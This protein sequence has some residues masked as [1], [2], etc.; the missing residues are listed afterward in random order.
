MPAAGFAV[1]HR[2]AGVPDGAN[3]YAGLTPLGGL[4]FG[5]AAGAGAMGFG[6]VFA[7]DPGSGVERVVYSFAG[8]ADG[9]LPYAGLAVRGRVLLGVTGRGGPANL[10]TI[11]ALDPLDGKE[12]MLHRFGGGAD[13][14][15][16]HDGL[17]EHE[18]TFYGTTTAGG[19]ACPDP[20]CGIVFA[21]DPRTRIESVLYRFTGQSDGNAPV[22]KLLWFGG[23]L[24]GATANGGSANSGV[25]YSIDVATGAQAV[26]HTFSGKPD[27]A[28]PLAGMIERAGKLYGTTAGGGAFGA[29]SVFEIDPVTGAEKVL[30]SF[31]AGTDGAFPEAPLVAG[32]RWLYGSTNLGGT[33]NGNGTLFEIDPDSGAEQVLHSF[34]STNGAVPQT[35]LFKL[36][37]ALF[38]TTIG[39]GV[40]GT[41]CQEIGCGTVFELKLRSR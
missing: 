7:I 19:G 15:Y 1:L 39:G 22:G 36:T 5:T 31:A 12:F 18:G 8:G 9:A 3:S 32:G 35:T 10:G 24:Y 25:L 38:G 13:G 40:T 21:F 4:L 28:Q 34:D 16:P 26:L 41:G 23:K 11:F 20:G 29:G 14:A 2:F 30:H 17:I 37:G 33:G 27:G 6:A